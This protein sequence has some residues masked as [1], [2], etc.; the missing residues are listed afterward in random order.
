[1]GKGETPKEKKILEE[2]IANEF[3]EERSPL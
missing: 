2:Y 1:M 3:E